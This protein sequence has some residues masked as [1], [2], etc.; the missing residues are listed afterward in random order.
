M[1]KNTSKPA[2]PTTCQLFRGPIVGP[3]HN[4]TASS[5]V[6][7]LLPFF[8]NGCGLS[9]CTYCSHHIFLNFQYHIMIVMTDTI[10][11]FLIH[12]GGIYGN[13]PPLSML[14]HLYTAVKHTHTSCLLIKT[15]SCKSGAEP[16]LLLAL[17]DPGLVSGSTFLPSG[18]QIY[19]KV[20]Q[21]GR[22][23]YTVRR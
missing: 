8:R 11:P 10:L 14:Q 21:W 16:V 12:L 17:N 6:P 22:G 7:L 1:G 3:A 23:G 19:L 13:T 2:D 20:A 9:C 15:S 5:L 4:E 18:H